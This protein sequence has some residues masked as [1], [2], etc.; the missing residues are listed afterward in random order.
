MYDGTVLHLTAVVVAVPACLRF[1][2]CC[3]QQLMSEQRITRVLNV[4]ITCQRPASI[5]DDHFRRIAVHDNYT[6]RIEPHLDEAVQFLGEWRL[7]ST[8]PS[9]N[10]STFRTKLLSHMR[11][12]VK[13]FPVGKVGASLKY[14][15]SYYSCSIAS[16][17]F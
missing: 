10:L 3:R 2:C 16:C 6:E 15:I 12:K 1:A 14:T 11:E 5:D 13:R 8:R 17:F 4:S 7:F 9:A